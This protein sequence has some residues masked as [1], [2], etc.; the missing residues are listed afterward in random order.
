M[1]TVII[2][3]Y[4]FLIALLYNNRKNKVKRFALTALRRVAVE[5]K[6]AIALLYNK[7]KENENVIQ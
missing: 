7:G 1:N 3:V 5:D 4:T 6:R 2:F